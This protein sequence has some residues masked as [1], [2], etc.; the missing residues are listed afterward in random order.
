MAIPAK[1]TETNRVLGAGN[2]RWGRRWQSLCN[3]SGE[4]WAYRF[5]TSGLSPAIPTLKAE[6]AAASA[7]SS[8]NWSRCSHVD[9]IRRLARGLADALV[10][11]RR[12]TD[13]YDYE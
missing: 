4:G 13:I 11:R 7:V 9:Q 2:G 8:E 6:G 1:P 3:P 5:R 12:R 10:R